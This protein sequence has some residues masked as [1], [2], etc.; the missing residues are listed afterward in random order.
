MKTHRPSHHTTHHKTHS[1][2]YHQPTVPEP[3]DKASTANL[4]TPS[5]AS[6]QTVLQLSPSWLWQQIQQYR[7]RLLCGNALA[8][9]ATLIA[10]PIPL[11]LPLMVD[12]V[13][14]HQPA[15]GVAL[16][17]GFLPVSWHS[18]TGYISAML[19]LII[20]MRILSQALNIWQTRQF[21]L[22]S[23]TITCQIRQ[24]LLD[25]L[26]R[27][28]FKAFESHGS[29]SVT[30]HMVTDIETI[31]SFLGSS[32]SRFLVSLLTVVGIALVLLWL[33]WRLGLFILLLNPVIIWLSRKMGQ[34]VQHLKKAENQSFERFQQRL[35]ET[36]DGLY[37]LRAANRD[38]QFLERLKTDANSIRQ[39]ADSYAWQADAAS[40]L[41]F[42][43]FLLGFEVFRAVAMVMVAVS[44]LTIGEIFAV[45][46]YLW[47]MLTPIQDLLSMQYSWF[48][49][50][51]AMGRLNRLFALEEEQQYSNP[52][53]PALAL[54][55]L[56]I[57][58]EHIRFRYHD[59]KQVLDNA[60][61]QIPAGKK[62][63]LVG[64]SGG[65]KSTLIQLLLGL[66]RK[67]EGDIRI[68]GTSIDEI[69][70]EAL[71]QQTAVVLQQPTLFNDTLRA[72]LTLGDSTLTDQQ[73]WDA[74]SVAQLDDVVKKLDKGLDTELG[75]QGLKLSGGQRQRLAIAR[76][77]LTDP[78][79]VIM[80]EATSALDTLTESRLQQA[81]SHFLTGRTTLIVAHRF[82]A[83]QDADIIYVLE[84]GK[85]VQTGQHSQLVKEPGL[86]RT[87]Y[88]SPAM[89][90]PVAATSEVN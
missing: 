26:G 25:K 6:K 8:I 54:P 85:V 19:L 49:A 56:A 89:I 72:N 61:L 23:K 41:S 32:L 13:L 63:A 9:I 33:D 11:L 66:Y 27:I 29:G 84:D 88:A 4:G 58:F 62:V 52:A 22:V 71:R 57:E 38:R 39:D 86:Y 47:F 59:E 74:L 24:S 20:L 80:D 3:A 55:T 70:Y 60:S 30:A 34:R 28:S 16:L 87:L 45:F 43:M 90:P 50:K 76:M 75:R 46:G 64:A 5:S 68:N 15:K 73:L 18:A 35:V 79:L 7:T 48:S 67:N 82:S 78:K 14:L 44:N 53:H 21:T 37:Q 12:E 65:G 17:Q 10:V 36:L 51:A 77:I 42:L 1:P 31:D 83:I 2:T 69:G 81:M 40:R